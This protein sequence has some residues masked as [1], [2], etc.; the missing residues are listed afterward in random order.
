MLGGSTLKVWAIG[1]A[2]STPG[3]DNPL[4]YED[5]LRVI[6]AYID[7]HGLR[8][9]VVVQLP[10]VIQ[11]KGFAAQRHAAGKTLDVEVVTFAEADIRRMLLDYFGQRDTRAPA[12]TDG[13]PPPRLRL[14][15][16]N[17]DVPDEP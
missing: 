5:L 8:E 3:A 4:R 2:L 14:L 16:S 7:A 15:P 6:G 17:S 1:D 11:V 10:N 12:P 9:V 13:P